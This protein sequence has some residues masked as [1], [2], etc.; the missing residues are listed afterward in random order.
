MGEVA[1][2]IAG[3]IVGVLFVALF[4]STIKPDF[5][6]TDKELI[7]K[8]SELAQV[9][10]F[11]EKYPDAR[12]EVSRSPYEAGPLVSFS[13]ERQVYPSGQFYTGIHSLTVSVNTRPYPTLLITCGLGWVSTMG[14]LESTDTIDA[15][16]QQCF[17]P[18]EQQ[19]TIAVNSKEG[20]GLGLRSALAIEREVIAEYPFLQNLVEEAEKKPEIII[21]STISTSDAQLLIGDERLQFETTC[22][23]IVC[24]DEVSS[25][26]NFG[27][28]TSY[29]IRIFESE[30]QFDAGSGDGAETGVFS[31]ETE[32]GKPVEVVEVN[33]NSIE[34]LI[35]YEED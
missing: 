4:S 26:V 29:L 12:A 2:V 1:P 32:V 31:P 23:E 19:M 22:L 9:K 20:A 10:Y 8:Y 27:D 14:S 25:F 30:D 33:D 5:M 3:L 35:E 6:L 18:E 13:A 16:E 15:I 28:N 7:S 17:Q 11:L 34:I 24:Y 21:R